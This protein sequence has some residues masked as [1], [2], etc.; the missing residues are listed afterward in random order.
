MF[1]CVWWREDDKSS[2]TCLSYTRFT[3]N[4]LYIYWYCCS[5]EGSSCMWVCYIHFVRPFFFFFLRCMLSEPWN[6]ICKS[7]LSHSMFVGIVVKETLW[8][9]PRPIKN[10]MW[11]NLK[12]PTHIPRQP[13]FILL[14]FPALETYLFHFESLPYQV[15]IDRTTRS[16]R[17]FLW[18]VL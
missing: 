3:L 16:I 8:Q 5:K 18:A 1:Y 14:P 2:C 13:K 11:E 10:W 15:I 12:R 6:C 7:T 4:L 9:C 17:P